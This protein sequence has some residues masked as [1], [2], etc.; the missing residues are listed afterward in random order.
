MT[1]HHISDSG[2]EYLPAGEEPNY[3]D[4]NPTSGTLVLFNSSKIAH[5]VLDTRDERI[6]I[7]G[8][9]NRVENENDNTSISKV[10]DRFKKVIKW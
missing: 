9:Y 10:R 3:V 7:V 6:A 4:V 2:S 8:W 1:Y 5:E